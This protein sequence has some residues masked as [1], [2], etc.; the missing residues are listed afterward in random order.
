MLTIY[1]TQIRKNDFIFYKYNI[2]RNYQVGDF[3]TINFNGTK[4]NYRITK[5]VS[6]CIAT[7]FSDNQCIESENI[8]YFC[9]P[10]KYIK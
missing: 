3:L 8:I 7:G 10:V 2:S 1:N 9:H 4:F 6:E 5:I